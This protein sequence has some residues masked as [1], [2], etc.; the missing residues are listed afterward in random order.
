M[1]GHIWLALGDYNTAVDVNER[2]IEVDQQYF[3]KTGV[4]GSYYGYYLHNY[5]F[6]L[7]ARSMQ[8]SAA[9]TRKAADAIVEAA[10]PMAQAMPDMADVIGVFATFARIRVADWDGLLAAK[11][12]S[13]SALAKSFWHYSRALSFRGKNDRGRPKVSRK[14][15]RRLPPSSIE[16]FHGGI[17]NWAKFWIWLTPLSKRGSNPPPWPR[18]RNGGKRSTFRTA[19]STMNRPRGITRCANL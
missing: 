8:G 3:A 17:T 11:P 16:T 1:P 2:A 18:S 12:G 19:S 5:Q 9:E 15:S 7:Y 13:E 14:N 4:I 10:K 6:V